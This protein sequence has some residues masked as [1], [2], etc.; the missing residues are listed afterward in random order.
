MKYDFRLLTEDESKYEDKDTKWYRVNEILRWGDDKEF[1]QYLRSEPLFQDNDFA[2]DTIYTLRDR[3]F[4]DELINYYLED[5]QDID[6]VLEIFIRTNSGGEPLSFSNLLM[7]YTTANWTTR[8][9][10]KSF[11]DLIHHQVYSI[12]KPNFIIN[13]DLVLKTCLVLFNDN[14]KFQVKNFDNSSVV[15]FEQNWDKVS[16]AIIEAFKLIESWGFNDSPDRI[17]HI[18]QRASGHHQQSSETH[19]CKAPHSTVAMSVPAER[20]IRRSTGQCAHQDSQGA[21]TP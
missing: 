4:K 8:D 15:K 12:G 21:R 5:K 7:S 14:I 2:Y 17:F 1:R 11:D 10:R 18:P 19:Q 6:Q 20:G 3:I 16:S 9:A 13:A